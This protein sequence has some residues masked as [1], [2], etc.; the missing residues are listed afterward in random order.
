M[1]FTVDRLPGAERKL[2]KVRLVAPGK[3]LEGF[4]PVK[5]L[6]L[7]ADADRPLRP[8]GEGRRAPRSV[9]LVARA[10]PEGT[11][12]ILGWTRPRWSWSSRIGGLRGD[13]GWEMADVPWFMVDKNWIR[14]LRNSSKPST[15]NHCL[16][17]RY[18]SGRR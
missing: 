18:F 12:D 1:T 2:V 13:P 9:P 8:Q 5:E 14:D 17:N 11:A 15:M 10:W 4:E 16:S 7:T 3:A 6:D